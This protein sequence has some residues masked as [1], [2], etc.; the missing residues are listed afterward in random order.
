MEVVAAVREL[1]AHLV[2]LVEHPYQAVV[3]DLP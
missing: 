3:G 2:E 1:L